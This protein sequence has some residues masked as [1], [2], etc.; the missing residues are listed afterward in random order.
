M[1]SQDKENNQLVTISLVIIAIVAVAISL[2]FTRAIMIPF[3]LALFVRILVD[4]IINFQIKNLRVHRFV[5][6]L[7]SIFIIIGSF[8]PTCAT[9]ADK[10]ATFSF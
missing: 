9:V 3:I 7:V 4:P 2:Y 5:A 6:I 8:P 10:S 1:I